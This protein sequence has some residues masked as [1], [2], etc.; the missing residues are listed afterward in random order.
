[1]PIRLSPHTKSADVFI[2]GD[3]L[4]DGDWE[5]LRDERREREYPFSLALLNGQTDIPGMA[6]CGA[7]RMTSL[8][9]PSATE[10]G[11]FAFS[12]CV[13][14]KSVS[15]PGA[16]GIGDYAFD[17]CCCL[18]ELSLP[19]SLEKIGANPFRLTSYD[20][21]PPI[22]NTISVHER[23]E[24]FESSGFALFTKDMRHLI[25]V[26]QLREERD[27]TCDAEVIGES[28]LWGSNLSEVS[29]NKTISIGK[30][31]FC[32]SSLS[33][34]RLPASLNRVDGNP[35]SYCQNL[36][37]INIDPL[38]ENFE[39]AGDFLYTSGQREILTAPLAME[40][41]FVHTSLEK[42][43]YRAFVGCDSLTKIIMP[44]AREIG[45][46]AF[47][48]CS[49]LETAIL[50]RVETVGEHA[51]EFCNSLT[52]IELPS[53]VKIGRNALSCWSLKS[54]SLPASLSE[55]EDN[56]FVYSHSLMSIEV[57]PGNEHYESSDGVL[58]S[59][60]LG[61]IISYPKGR[62]GE[63]SYFEPESVGAFAYCGLRNLNCI[64][65]PNASDI[66][67]HAFEN[68]KNLR[69]LQL[70]AIP[71]SVGASAFELWDD[72]DGC[73]FTQPVLILTPGTAN[74]GGDAMT[75]FPN[76]SAAVAASLPPGVITLR[77]GERLCLSARIA[78]A[79]NCQW[80]KRAA[81]D[82]A[83]ENIG[84]PGDAFIKV[85]AGPSDEG[86]YS[87]SFK[88]RSIPYESLQTPSVRVRV[89]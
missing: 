57:D 34:I 87:M 60:G 63:L 37:E 79:A 89:L 47:R 25:A 20:G 22:L 50:P 81:P 19:E 30:D 7:W 11:A 14:L 83:W 16:A 67:A 12:N 28:A 77:P 26:L 71:P 48:H 44:N 40:G 74:Y 31:A 72:I 66:G 3:I 18:E 43:A 4:E 84:A 5:E 55:I 41:E 51:F 65:L 70:G 10:V 23:N 13:Q 8:T 82:G 61:R 68:C 54:V 64:A 21:P 78:G 17:G 56:P 29:L 73:A 2:K 62:D 85:P 52:E 42:V 80:M 27:F 1:M 15:L 86:S 32:G 24:H 76:E 58:Y 9:C 69:V 53:A 75:R 45:G 49:K 36:R 46:Y 88:H 35:F 38:N 6:L 33:S 39:S 59:K